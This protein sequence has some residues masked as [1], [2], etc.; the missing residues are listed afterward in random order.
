MLDWAACQRSEKVEASLASYTHLQGSSIRF[1]LSDHEEVKQLG[2]NSA[3]VTY[4][5]FE[6]LC[7]AF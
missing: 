5:F 6:S 1:L 7:N 2:M 3:K 4:L